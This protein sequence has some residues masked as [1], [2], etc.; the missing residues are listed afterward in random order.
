M[1]GKAEY[2]KQFCLERI[3]PGPNEK[4]ALLH[5]QS[6]QMSRYYCCRVPDNV[7]GIRKSTNCEIT[8]EYKNP[9]YK[10]RIDA[11]LIKFK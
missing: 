8:I 11:F 6:H 9:N 7:E 10:Q 1:I 4:P 3:T 5:D 2:D